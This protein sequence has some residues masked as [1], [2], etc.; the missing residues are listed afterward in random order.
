MMYDNKWLIQNC[1]NVDEFTVDKTKDK[2]YIQY[3]ETNSKVMALHHDW[4][5][6]SDYVDVLKAQID[7]LSTSIDSDDYKSK[8]N[9]LIT[10]LTESKNALSINFTKLFGAVVNRLQESAESDEWFSEEAQSYANY[11]SSTILGVTLSSGVSK[12]SNLGSPSISPTLETSSPQNYNVASSETPSYEGNTGS[13]SGQSSGGS[14]G[15][16]SSGDYNSDST[17]QGLMQS[18]PQNNDVMVNNGSVNSSPSMNSND[19]ILEPLSATNVQYSASPASAV[20]NNG[21][22]DASKY[23]NKPESG[24]VVTTDNPKYNLSDSDIELLT[25]IVSAESDKSYDDALA[26]AST[27]F[28]RCETPKWASCGGSNPVKQATAKDQ[29][30]VYQHGSYKKYMGSGAPDTCRQAVLDVINGVRNHKY[31]SFRSNGST[32]YSSNMI[33]SSGNRYK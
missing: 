18:A 17:S 27:I 19:E 11:I 5:V 14:Q 6:V 29:F 33:T 25:A 32:R 16:D 13:S 1:P 12:T 15:L 3:S 7:E 9:D 23:T 2:Y 8:T 30:V 26:V 20:N 21:L 28:N 31:L 10:A 4:K 24:F 22:V